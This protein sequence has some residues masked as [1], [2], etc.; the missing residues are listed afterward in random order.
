[1][2]FQDESDIFKRQNHGHLTF[3]DVVLSNK[4]CGIYKLGSPIWDN[5]VDSQIESFSNRSATRIQARPKI[6]KKSIEG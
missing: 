6:R 2:D 5:T 4:C 3:T 1:M